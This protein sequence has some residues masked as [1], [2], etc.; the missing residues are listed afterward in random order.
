MSPGPIYNAGQKLWQKLR[1]PAGLNASL[2]VLL[3]SDIIPPPSSNIN[4]EVVAH[5]QTKTSRTTLKL[6]EG[7]VLKSH[8]FYSRIHSL[9]FLPNYFVRHFLN[10]ENRNKNCSNRV[11]DF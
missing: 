7:V 6:G 3:P 4:V 10:F 2:N 8:L 1:N 11:E 9:M 5:S